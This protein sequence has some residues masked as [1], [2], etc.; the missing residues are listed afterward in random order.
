MSGCFAK[1]VEETS[2]DFDWQKSVVL[3]IGKRLHWYGY[4]PVRCRANMPIKD[5]Q[6]QNLALAFGEKF[7]KRFKLFPPRSEVVPAKNALG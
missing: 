5:S 3:F 4:S 6:G 7:L 2:C 1:R